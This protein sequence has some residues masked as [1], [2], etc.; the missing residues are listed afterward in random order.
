MDRRLD[1]RLVG[2]LQHH[3]ENA[4]SSEV[5]AAQRIR[6]RLAVLEEDVAPHGRIGSGDAGE[7][8][9]ARPDAMEG[10]SAAH[11]ELA[12]VL[13]QH[14]GQHVRQVTDDG[15]DAIVSAGVDVRRV[16]LPGRATNRCSIS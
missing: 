14:V 5:T 16:G 12:R 9:E 8:L 6:E 11:L 4:S 3:A 2:G 10:P 7:V 15:H 1:L 13:H